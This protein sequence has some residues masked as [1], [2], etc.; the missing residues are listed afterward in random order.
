MSKLDNIILECANKVLDGREEK[1]GGYIDPT[2]RQ[3]KELFLELL[4]ET[5]WENRR[6]GPAEDEPWTLWSDYDELRQK[7]EEL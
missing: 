2:K 6:N 3:I 4:R 5:K 7:V 1:L